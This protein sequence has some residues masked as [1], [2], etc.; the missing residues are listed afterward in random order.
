M[1][2]KDRKARSNSGAPQRATDFTQSAGVDEPTRTHTHSCPPV[3]ANTALKPG[4]K[5]GQ[6]DGPWAGEPQEMQPAQ[7]AFST[8]LGKENSE[9]WPP[10]PRGL[11]QHCLQQGTGSGPRLALPFVHLL[12][13][14]LTAS[15]ALGR[16]LLA[17]RADGSNPLAL[18]FAQKANLTGFKASTSA[19]Y[20]TSAFPDVL[21]EKCQRKGSGGVFS[22]MWRCPTSALYPGTVHLPPPFSPP[23][24]PAQTNLLFAISNSPQSLFCHP[25]ATVQVPLP[26]SR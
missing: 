22:H 8:C 3:H 13:S 24:P 23:A 4:E 2:E 14:G 12:S 26:H 9:V 18:G 19:N 20:L 5:S 7:A 25:A 10:S 11:C 1:S 15:I 6:T 21:S 16:E 17:T